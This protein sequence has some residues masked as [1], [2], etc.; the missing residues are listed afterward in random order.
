MVIRLAESRENIQGDAVAILK[1]VVIMKLFIKM[2]KFSKK[3]SE[4]SDIYK[5][6]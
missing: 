2:L 6:T 4:H 3:D 5:T 1:S